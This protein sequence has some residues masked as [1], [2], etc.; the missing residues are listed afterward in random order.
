MERESTG[1]TYHSEL[2]QRID[3]ARERSV[4]DVTS[5]T[6]FIDA[7]SS[8]SKKLHSAVETEFGDSQLIKMVPE[9]HRLV[10]GTVEV[11]DMNEDAKRFITEAITEFVAVFEEKWDI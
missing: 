2:L 3:S 9:W 11:H 4:R 7:L 1:E 6:E 8:F 10:G 5:N